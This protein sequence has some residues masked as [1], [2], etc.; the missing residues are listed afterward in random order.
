MMEEEVEAGECMKRRMEEEEEEEVE[1]EEEQA[2]RQEVGRRMK[3]AEDAGGRGERR[4]RK[5]R[6][7]K[8]IV[9]L[10]ANAKISDNSIQ[11]IG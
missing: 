4:E 10:E 2:E 11:R 5:G 6:F 3:G 7:V 8:R 9:E 1:Q